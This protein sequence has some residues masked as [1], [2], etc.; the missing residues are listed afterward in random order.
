MAGL[1]VSSARAAVLAAI[2]SRNESWTVKELA[3]RLASHPNT[4]R[5]HL[6]ELVAAGLVEPATR[7]SLGRGRPA[8]RYRASIAIDIDAG[9]N[10]LTVALVKQVDALPGGAEV[11]RRAGR[12]W[13]AQIASRFEG[14]V[15]TQRVVDTLDEMGFQ[16][17]A[18]PSVGEDEEILLR[19]CPILSMARRNPDIICNMHLG[20]VEELLDASDDPRSPSLYPMAHP[21]GCLVRLSH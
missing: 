21:N 15:T 5:G 11:A 17:T 6:A 3:E 1:A 20:V 7:S 4:I 9:V 12:Q 14:P 18:H 2:R 13:G 10:D 16:P 19:A 8:E